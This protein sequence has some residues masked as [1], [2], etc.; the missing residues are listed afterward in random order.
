[1]P[2]FCICMQPGGSLKLCLMLGKSR[3]LSELRYYSG[4]RL[5]HVLYP[6]LSGSRSRRPGSHGSILVALDT[7]YT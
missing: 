5:H 7:L 6:L 1:M 2:L 4:P 3:W